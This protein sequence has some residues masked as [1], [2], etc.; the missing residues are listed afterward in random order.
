L[1]QYFGQPGLRLRRQLCGARFKLQYEA[2]CRR[3]LQGQ[4]IAKFLGNRLRGGGAALHRAIA[5][6][7]GYFI[8]LVQPLHAGRAFHD[9]RR[10]TA[11]CLGQQGHPTQRGTSAQDAH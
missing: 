3:R 7:S 8:G 11:I 5:L 1:H 9:D 2:L 6:Y 4:Q 10:R